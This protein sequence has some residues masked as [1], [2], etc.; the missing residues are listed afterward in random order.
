[1][2]NEQE[3]DDVNAAIASRTAEPLGFGDGETL[4]D[5]P[6]TP[7]LTPFGP[8]MLFNLNNLAFISAQP[9]VPGDRTSNQAVTIGYKA[10][11]VKEL[12]GEAAME[13]RRFADAQRASY[14]AWKV[15]DDARKAQKAEKASIRLQKFIADTNARC[16]AGREKAKADTA[17]VPAENTG[18]SPG[19]WGASQEASQSA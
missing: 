4:S 18:T 2:S 6:E 9:I 10:G 1:M 17:K 8:H 5:R 19:G 11:L 16:M 15:K 12:N 14:A 13:V 3:N 7:T